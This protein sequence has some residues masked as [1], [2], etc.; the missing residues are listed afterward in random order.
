MVD[1][2]KIK[3]FFKLGKKSKEN[4]RSIPFF[5]NTVSI[6]TNNIGASTVTPPAANQGIWAGDKYP[7]GFGPT[8][9]Y[10]MDYW[11]LRARSGQL[12]RDNLYARGLIRR[13]VTNEINTGLTLEALP[14]P[15]ILGLTDEEI[16]DLSEDIETKHNIWAKNPKL[17]DYEERRTHGKLQREERRE[18][19]ISGD[20]LKII[21]I[22]RITGLPNIRLVNGS[23]V[24]TPFDVKIADGHKI[25]HGVEINKKGKHVAYWIT[26]DNNE[27]QRINAWGPRSGRRIA[28]L[29]YGTDK[30]MD[31]V[32]GEPLLSLIMQSLKEIDRYRDSALRKATINAILAMW[33]EKGE[34]KMG[35]LPSLAGATSKTK[36]AVPDTESTARE[37][38]IQG[39]LPGVVIDGLQKNE[40]INAHTTA[41]TDINFGLFEEAIIQSI[42]WSMEIPPNILRL[43]F[44]SNY[45]ASQGENNEYKVYLNMSRTRIGESSLQPEY[46]EWFLSSVL[47][48]DINA[49]GFFEAWKDPKKYLIYG[50]WVASD[51]S[52]AI[53]PSTDI[54]KTARGYEA[55][56]EMGAITR[57][58]TAKETTGTRFEKNVKTLKREN[59]M[60]ADAQRPLLELEKEMG[61]AGQNVVMKKLIKVLAESNDLKES[62]ET[63]EIQ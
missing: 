44:S 58:R 23:L 47:N 32:R 13:F 46:N 4:N 61:E 17:C 34:D 50:A 38:T 62:N 9:L 57:A 27:P 3:N 8:Q 45:S 22:S 33:V 51:W 30:R 36:V 2:E 43:A 52:G 7:G 59:E 1:Y 20:V 40:K 5:N 6:K 16:S 60:L 21:T 10:D 56:I 25:K 19:L 28:W 15:K 39:Q 48:N 24:R 26:N 29:V 53:K 55:F 11:E 63:E 37:L 31:D 18:A 12:F 41:G 54:V 35:S 49:P 14:E 42:A